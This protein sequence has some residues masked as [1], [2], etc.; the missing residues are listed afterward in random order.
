MS[1][2]CPS[3]AAAEHFGHV[4]HLRGRV[5]PRRRRRPSMLSMQP[6]SPSTTASAPRLL[7]VLALV[8][9]EPRGDLAEL[10][11]ERAAEA[12]ARLRL[13]HFAAAARPG[14]LASSARGWRLDAHLAQAGAAVVI[15]DRARE[16]ARERARASSTFDE[17]VGE[18]VGARGKRLRR[19][20]SIAGVV[21]EEVRRSAC[22]S[23]RCT[24]P[25]ARPGSR[26]PRT[27][28]R[29]CAPARCASARS[30]ELYAG[31]P[32]QVCVGGT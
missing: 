3:Y 21:G 16:R 1:S 17:E 15:G 32:Q 5:S 19:A 28:R 11:R 30:P 25:T 13:G 12:A 8:V 18:L 14:I 27:R 7:D 29:A 2:P 9:G 26:S 23:C 24:I 4:Q 31:W 6:R 10:D 20:R 22:G